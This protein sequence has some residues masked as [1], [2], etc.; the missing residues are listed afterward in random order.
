MQNWIL[1][2]IL[3]FKNWVVLAEMTFVLLKKIVDQKS[4]INCSVSSNVA[5]NHTF[6]VRRTNLSLNFLDWLSL[7]IR[8]S[9]KEIRFGLIIDHFDDIFITYVFLLYGTLLTIICIWHTGTAANNTS[10]LE[11]EE[12]SWIIG[13]KM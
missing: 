3:K 1:Y 7:D 2:R 13:D 8:L 12:F 10:S 9:V 4:K 6:S 5:W 11:E